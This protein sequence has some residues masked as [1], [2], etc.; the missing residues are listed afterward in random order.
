VT[1]C[2]TRTFKQPVNA[3]Q[4]VAMVNR[5]CVIITTNLTRTKLFVW[6]RRIQ[7]FSSYLTGNTRFT[8]QSVNAVY[9]N[10]RC[11]LWEPHGTH[12]QTL[13]RQNWVVLLLNNIV[14][15]ETSVIWTANC[16][17]PLGAGK[18]NFLRTFNI[19]S[20]LNGPRDEKSECLLSF[21]NLCFSI[22]CQLLLLF[23]LSSSTWLNYCGV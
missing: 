20:V 3:R 2:V 13:S 5:N 6:Y 23:L 18:L 11:L 21:H 19:V 4:F 22:T 15:T 8:D 17:S 12:K 16:K 1:Y 14:G 10:D 7:K 9:R